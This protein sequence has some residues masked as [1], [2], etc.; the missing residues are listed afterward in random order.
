MAAVVVRKT[1]SPGLR[2][3]GQCVL[4]GTLVQGIDPA[5]VVDPWHCTSVVENDRSGVFLWPDLQMERR[6]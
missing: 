5:T 3:A 2:T 1:E 6:C 4:Q